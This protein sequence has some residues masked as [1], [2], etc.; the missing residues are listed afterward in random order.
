LNGKEEKE[1]LA[2]VLIASVELLQ[3]KLE[4][5][6]VRSRMIH[7]EAS[8]RREERIE[9]QEAPPPPPRCCGFGR[10]ALD[11]PGSL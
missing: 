9:H 8:G 5:G 10:E 11:P 1:L 3:V 2:L 7:V 6:H 4:C